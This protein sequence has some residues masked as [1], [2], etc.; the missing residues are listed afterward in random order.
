MGRDA[1]KT[2]Q[3]KTFSHIEKMSSLIKSSQSQVSTY[4][5][6]KNTHTSKTV[7]A[8]EGKRAPIR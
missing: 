1:N 2:K 7:E 5:K 6:N 4:K 3:S 8:T